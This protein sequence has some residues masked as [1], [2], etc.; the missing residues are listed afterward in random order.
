M[1]YQY[2]II[3]YVPDV[4]RGEF[5][6]IGLL[7]GRDG[8]DWAVRFG[9][10]RG[11]ASAT[12]AH[13]GRE[14][15]AWQDDFSRRIGNHGSPQLDDSG[16][17]TAWMRRIRGRQASS[18]QFSAPSPVAAQSAVQALDLLFPHLVERAGT[19]RAQAL[20]RA[21]LRS[22]VR[23]TLQSRHGLVEGVSLFVQ[24]RATIG[25]QRATIDLFQRQPASSR[26]VS[27]WAFNVAVIDG[28]EQQLQASNYFFSL[29]RRH[30]AHLALGG[31]KQVSL[32]REVLATV[33]FD[34]PSTGRDAQWRGEVFAAAQEAWDDNGITS[35]SLQQFR[36]ETEA[37]PRL[38][39]SSGAG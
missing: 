15:R 21:S 5:V 3:R 14:L 39:A 16:I 18:I 35:V 11:G 17:D 36:A 33:V 4:A 32:H 30:G 12:T 28:L 26:L 34:P 25:K 23:A 29:L 2:W 7:A 31:A 24:P 20:T 8:A 9:S 10:H 37:A 13:V 6:N 22:E 1:T 27:V 38:V 19:T